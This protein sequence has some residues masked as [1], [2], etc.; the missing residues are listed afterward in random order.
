MS[1]IKSFIVCV[2]CDILTILWL[3]WLISFY[4]S[5]EHR[6]ATKPLYLTM[7]QAVTLTPTLVSPTIRNS[8]SSV[9]LNVILDRPLPLCPWGFH[10]RASFFI[11]LSSLLS[12]WPIYFHSFILYINGLLLVHSHRYWFDITIGHLIPKLGLRHFMVNAWVT[13]TPTKSFPG[14]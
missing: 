2:L 10:S 13:A 3:T 5:K 11:L 8:W 7:L 4:S 6:T 9:H 1:H 12:V 14:F